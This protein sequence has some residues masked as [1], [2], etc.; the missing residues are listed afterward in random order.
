[1]VSSG[2][3]SWASA[4]HAA[5]S[6]RRATPAATPRWR[7][8]RHPV[9][10]RSR[11]PSTSTR[12]VTREHFLASGEMQIS[13][14]PFAEAM[15]RDLGGYS[16]DHVPTDIY[17]DTSPNAQGPW[18]DLA[19]FSTGVESYEYSK[20][21]MNT[22][23]FESGAGT[24]LVYGPLVERERRDRRTAPRRSSRRSSSTSREASHALGLFVFPAGHVPA[25]PR[26]SARHPRSGDA[27]PTGAGTGAEN[28]LGWPGHLAD[29]ARLREL[30]S[31]R[32]IR[33]ATERST[34]RSA[35]TT[36][37]ARPAPLV[38][39]D[40]ECDATTL[41]LRDRAAQIDP[42]I[43]PGADGFSRVEVR[44]VGPQLPAG[45]AR[46]DRGRASST[47]ADG[48]P[49]ERRRA[50]QPGRRRRRH[51]RAD[52]AG[53]YLGS[54]DIEGFQAQMFIHEVDN[55]AEDWLAQPDDRRRRDALGLRVVAAAL[56]YDYAAPLR[57]FPGEIAV[58][59]TDDGSGFP[60]PAYALA[61]ADSSLLDLVGVAIGLRRVLRAH[62]HEER[63]RRRRAA[64]A[65]RSSTAIRSRPTISSPTARPRC[66]TARSRCCA[67]R[68]S[69]SIGCTAIRDRRARRRRDDDRRDAVAR[70]RPSRR[71]R[72]RTRSSRCARRCARS[73]RSSSSTRTTRP[74]RRSSR[75]P[76]DAL[77]I[78]PSGERR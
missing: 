9:T 70:A 46:L 29:R 13:G 25:E 61:S 15:G 11:R 64:G 40:Y 2:L 23:A 52:G 59:E 44:P 78:A 16:R 43:T 49:R 10:R 30:R 24:S 77:P 50:G 36:I 5:P 72:S 31:R 53:T 54:S 19:G 28:P 33:R 57:W 68:W 38:C 69:T 27:N 4:P 39:A 37:P 18:I 65:R 60:K 1:M 45:H 7:R 8:R 63:G 67:W 56:A 76:L 14:E 26:A 21:P 42:T 32:S 20:Q 71:R 3:W 12:F 17:F 55:R 41:H 35:R 47:V 66:T 74:T 58:T 62:R 48:R 75:T 51:R 73:A 6:R 34:A 22:I